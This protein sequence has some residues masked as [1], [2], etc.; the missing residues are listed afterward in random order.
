MR[1]GAGA[2]CPRC[3]RL[4][5]LLDFLTRD[6]PTTGDLGLAARAGLLGVEADHAAPAVSSSARPA[7]IDVRSLITQPQLPCR[8]HLYRGKA[9]LGNR[10][11][12]GCPLVRHRA[13]TR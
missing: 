8:N 4:E 11:I 6:L 2:F 7:A 12:V 10:T 1:S 9:R 13:R 3:R 5:C